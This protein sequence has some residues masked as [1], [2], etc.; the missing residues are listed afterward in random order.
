M[1]SPSAS[2]P[3]AE[4]RVMTMMMM[5]MIAMMMTM[6]MMMVMIAMMMTMMTIDEPAVGHDDDADM[7]RLF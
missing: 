3:L 7:M 6:V 1:P 5:M 4:G 2:P